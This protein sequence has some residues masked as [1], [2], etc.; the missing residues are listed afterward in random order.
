MPSLFAQKQRKH[1]MIDAITRGIL[2]EFGSAILDFYQQNALWINII[3]FAY[4]FILWRAKIAY[5][6]VKDALLVDLEQKFGEQIYQKD[7]VWFQKILQK[8]EPDWQHL[9]DTTQNPLISTQKSFWFRQ[10]SPKA[11]KEHFT[12]EII[13]AIVQNDRA[14]RE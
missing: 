1:I 8:N 12:P 11:L 5:T 10:K 13:H 2:G 3:L 7:F 9:A 6:K 14:K 4:A